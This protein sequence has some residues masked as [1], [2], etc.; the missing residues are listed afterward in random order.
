MSS[1]PDNTTGSATDPV[2]VPSDDLH[3]NLLRLDRLAN[4]GLVAASVAHEIKNGLVAITTFVE[5]LMEKEQEPEMAGLVRKEL[6]RIDVLT[7]QMLRLASPRQPLTNTVNIHH[8]LDHSLHLLEH[9][10]NI[11]NIKLTRDYRAAPDRILGDESQLHQAF[12]NLLLNGVEAI[13]KNGELTVSTEI[14]SDK[15]GGPWL[16]VRIRDTGPGI[17]PEALAH[18]FHP[19]F[20]TKANGTGLGLSICRRVA[21]EHRGRV[22]V[23]SPPGGGATF[24]FSLPME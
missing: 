23:Q 11:R 16:M 12:V 13:D 6:K 3:E 1:S 10:M 2:S 14:Q 24:T 9:Q 7:T 4:L 15:I 20:T 17:P 18:L 21:E 8:L 5:I 22:D 19:F